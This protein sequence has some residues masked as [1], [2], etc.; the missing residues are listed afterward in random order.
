[1]TQ[2]RQQII[3]DVSCTTNLLLMLGAKDAA[4]FATINKQARKQ[5]A[6]LTTLKRLNLNPELPLPVPLDQIEELLYFLKEAFQVMK[7]AIPGPQAERLQHLIGQEL[8]TTDLKN[9]EIIELLNQASFNKIFIKACKQ[10]P[11]L[12]HM[13]MN[14]PALTEKVSLSEKHIT[15]FEDRVATARRD[16]SRE[17]M[18]EPIQPF[19]PLSN[20]LARLNIRLAPLTM[21]ALVVDMLLTIIKITLVLTIRFLKGFHKGWSNKTVAD[22]SNAITTSRFTH[23]KT[24]ELP[25]NTSEKPLANI[26]KPNSAIS[27][28]PKVFNNPLYTQVDMP[29]VTT[30]PSTLRPKF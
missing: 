7:D 22:I 1:M 18:R 24:N 3:T 20:G 21:V 5:K 4:V 9:Q 6:K 29:V 19:S 17:M 11:R 28:N 8:W 27:H 16:S 12:A 2:T 25:L 14:I 30:T 26:S 13:A 23:N 15:T 10:Q